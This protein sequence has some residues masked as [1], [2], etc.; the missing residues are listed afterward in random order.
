MGILSKFKSRAPHPRQPTTA[1]VAQSSPSAYVSEYMAAIDRTERFGFESPPRVLVRKNCVD[2]NIVRPVLLDYFGRSSPKS[3]IGQTA[4][5]HFALVPL[6]YDKTGIPF[7]LTIGW[8]VRKGKPIYQHDEELVQRFVQEKT[9]AWLSLGCPFHLW[10]TSPA[11]E[12]LDV[13]FAMNLGWAK[14]R[15]DCSRLLVYQSVN[16]LRSDSVYH[17]TLVGPGFFHKTGGVL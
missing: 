13:T 8:M 16:E 17:P 15:Q 10:L 4:A 6:L 12:I 3:M 9:Q 7:N 1:E 14:N 11:C 5:I 2:M